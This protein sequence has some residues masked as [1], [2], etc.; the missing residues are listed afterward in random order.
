LNF[1][2]KLINASHRAACSLSRRCI[3]CCDEEENS[4]AASI[5]AGLRVR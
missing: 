1:V 3:R 5:S 4:Q 2:D